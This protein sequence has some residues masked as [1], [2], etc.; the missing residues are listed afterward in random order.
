MSNCTKEKKRYVSVQVLY[1]I[2]LRYVTL[3]LRRN[4]FRRKKW[5]ENHCINIHKQYTPNCLQ[6]RNTD[7]GEIMVIPL[8][9]LIEKRNEVEILTDFIM[10]QIVIKFG[11]LKIDNFGDTMMYFNDIIQWWQFHEFSVAC[12]MIDCI[13]T[14]DYLSTVI[15]FDANKFC[16]NVLHDPM[17]PNINFNHFFHLIW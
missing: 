2:H 9:C 6:Y 1:K 11:C 13:R 5:W 15:N 7:I 8:S 17:F 16:H 12:M 4:Y 10:K 3:W 14:H